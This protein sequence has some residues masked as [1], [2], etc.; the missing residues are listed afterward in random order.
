MGKENPNHTKKRTPSVMASNSTLKS[1]VSEKLLHLLADFNFTP[2]SIRVLADY[3]VVLVSNGKC[4]SEAKAELEPFLGHITAGFVSWLW[5]IL[6]EDSNHSN[7]NKSPS[8]SENISGPNSSE[9]QDV[10][11]NIQSQNSGSGLVPRSQPPVLSNTLAEETNE[12]ASALSCKSNE[13]F[14]ATSAFENNPDGSLYGCSCKTKASAEVLPPYEQNLQYAKVHRTTPPLKHSQETNVGGRRLFSR[15]A[16]AIFHQNGIRPRTVWDRLGK[17]TENDSSVKHVDECV[18]I[19]RQMLEN[20]FLGLGQNTWIPTVLVGEVKNISQ[21]CNVRTYRSNGGR[22]RQLNDFI[23]ISSTT[24][25]TWDR[26]EEISRK[27]TV[28]PE[29]YTCMLKESHASCKGE[30]SNICNKCSKSGLDAPLSSIPEK[31]PQDKSGVGEEELDSTQ[32]LISDSAFPAET[33]G[34]KPVQ[35]QLVDMKSRLRKLETEICKLKSQPLIKDGRHALS[36]SSGSVDH[37]LKDG[38]ES[39]TVFVTNVHVAATQDA[40]RSYFA[41]CG[42]VNRVIKLTNTSTINQKRSAYITFATEE[43]VDKALTLNGTNFFSRIIWVRKA[44]KVAVRPTWSHHGMQ[45]NAIFQQKN[46]HA[47]NVPQQTNAGMM[48]IDNSTDSRRC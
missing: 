36:S 3:V 10:S 11:A 14:R 24:S 27:F 35:A 34:I 46:N 30:K 47:T 7:A 42:P 5:D 44:G 17:P 25:D 33:G 26:E 39:R 31:T 13:N 45:R 6:S 48:L 12:Y 8:G 20:S 41:R 4:Q 29:N 40:L 37:P 18:N 32:T 22:K 23:L 19:K 2:D 28:E 38:V 16:G 9:A 21:N 1:S 15:A 43:S